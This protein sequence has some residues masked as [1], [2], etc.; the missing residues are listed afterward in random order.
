MS[1][2][3]YDCVSGFF[4][5]DASDADSVII[6][7]IPVRFGLLDDSNDRWFKLWQ[8][9]R[10]M[11]EKADDQTSYKVFILGRHGEA[12]HNVGE[13]KYGTQAWDDYWSKLN[14]DGEI[15]WGPDPMLTAL[16]EEQARMV[17][18][19]WKNESTF[20][21]SVPI[22][23]YCSP[24]TR[25]TKT[26]LLTFDGLPTSANHPVVIVEN[27][28]EEYGVHSCDKRNSRT[29]ISNHLPAFVFEQDFTEDDQIWTATERETHAHAA[30]RV[31]SVLD[32]IFN[33]D[34]NDFIS[35]TTHGGV[36]NGL[37][38]AVGRKHYALPTGGVLPIIIKSILK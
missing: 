36:I 1:S 6:G 7:A 26:C 32:W 24:L 37:L 20:G 31:K 10:T 13:A 18:Q 2:R 27:C 8:K 12:F 38:T 11:N 30:I 35:I 14:G 5:Q 23:R 22:S 3:S 33:T 4:L 17:N 25:A 28:R 19:E 34:D 9:V 16:G 29:W 21:L 15:I